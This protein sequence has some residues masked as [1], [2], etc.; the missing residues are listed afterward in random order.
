MGS[1]T[2]PGGGGDAT[3][4]ESL[5]D[6]LGNTLTA[7][8]GAANVAHGAGDGSDHADVATNTVHSGGDGSDHLDVHLVDGA[9]YTV[10]D[11][12]GYTTILVDCDGADRTITLP[13]AADNENRIIHV[14]KIDAGAD[15]VIV[16]GEVA[17]E[18]IDG[19]V[20]TS[21]FASPMTTQYM[22][23]SFQCDGS[24]WYVI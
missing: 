14:K 24:D 21:T 13:T 10:L 23:Y 6:G 4:A 9:D 16:E 2:P 1:Y 5:D 18:T 22:A 20:N 11:D 8:Q 15:E 7:V 12:D 19:E 17:G 3:T